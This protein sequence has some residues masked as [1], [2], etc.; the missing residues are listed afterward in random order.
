M[1]A[2]HGSPVIAVEVDA[3]ASAVSAVFVECAID[4]L[5]RAAEWAVLVEVAVVSAI[6]AWVVV[7]PAAQVQVQEQ[8][9][10][11]EQERQHPAYLAS[12]DSACP[13]LEVEERVVSV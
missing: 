3:E 2:G 9:Q 7:V 4:A 1:V 6:S 11:Q 12:P 10:E 13:C 8:E 5:E